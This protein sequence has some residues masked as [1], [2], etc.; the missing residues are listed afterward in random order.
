LSL[1]IEGA[2]FQR[3]AANPAENG[4]G[5]RGSG[6]VLHDDPADRPQGEFAG[7]TTVA[8]GGSH[9]SFI[10]LPVIPRGE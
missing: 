1:R 6:V 7:V 9:D 5:K 4:I 2:D 3:P 10:V 8:S